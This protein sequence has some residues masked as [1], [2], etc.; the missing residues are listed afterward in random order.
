MYYHMTLKRTIF[1]KLV[2][3]DQIVIVTIRNW[4]VLL[5]DTSIG[6]FDVGE[7]VWGFPQLAFLTKNFEVILEICT[8]IKL[9][10]LIAPTILN[11]T[12]P[13]PIFSNMI[14]F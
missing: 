6:F 8:K 5:S 12:N 10:Y 7:E 2:R 4:R 14:H 13:H 9:S 11:L 3:V 1:R